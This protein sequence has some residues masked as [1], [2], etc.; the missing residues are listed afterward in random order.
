MYIYQGVATCRKP[1]PYHFL[2]YRCTLVWTMF[3]VK[4]YHPYLVALA[5]H[6]HFCTHFQY[7]HGCRSIVLARGVIPVG[8]LIG[9]Y[10]FI[11]LQWQEVITGFRA[12]MPRHKK[13]VKMRQYENCFTGGEAV[14]WLHSHLQSTGLFGSPSR[15][16]V[17]LEGRPATK[18]ELF[19][20]TYLVYRW[21][22][23]FRSFWRVM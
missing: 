20:A 2:H 1:Q 6:P 7:L 13:R 14:E 23:F 22:D 9:Q 19:Q 15:Q 12:G 18:L 21:S 17:G 3:M 16:Q 8:G 4:V 10:V 5:C 11:F